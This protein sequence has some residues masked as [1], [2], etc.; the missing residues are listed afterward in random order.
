MTQPKTRR[1]LLTL[2]VIGAVG[3]VA[4]FGV[5]S[6]FSSS[7]TNTGNQFSAGTVAIGS[8]DAGQAMFN[9]VIDAKPTVTVNKCITVTYTGSLPSTV[10]LYTTDGPL[11]S[12]AQYVNVTI[13]PGSFTGGPPAF[14]S[15]T[16]FT[17]SGSAVYSGTLSNFQST[18]NSFANG[19]SLAGPS[20][21][22]WSRNDSVV[23]DFAYTVADNNSANSQVY[24]S[25]LTTGSHSYKFEAQ[26]N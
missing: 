4:S 21:S 20:A 7:T 19:V 18:D 17:A 9:N 25:P 5:F 2:V 6:A 15:C 11:G 22:A 13:T 10:K 3:A 16:G 23:Y 26:N 24:A 1:A 14:P 8:N 12:L